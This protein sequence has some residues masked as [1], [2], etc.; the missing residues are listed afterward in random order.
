VCGAVMVF[1]VVATLR[2]AASAALGGGAV[3]TLRD[4]ERGVGELGWPHVIMESWQI[5][6]RC[7]SLVLAMVGIVRPT[8]LIRS[9]A[10]SK[11][12]SCSDGIGTWQWVG[13]S[14]HVSAKQKR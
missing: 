4:V 13:Y 9:A 12:F 14:R 5:A 1:D 11:V 6:A 7:L 2:G 10:R 3:S 8:C